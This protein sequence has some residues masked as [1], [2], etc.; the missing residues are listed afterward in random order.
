M[1]FVSLTH[2]LGWFLVRD[3]GFWILRMVLVSGC[4]A[5]P[6]FQFKCHS[7]T[8]SPIQVPPD[9]WQMT[10]RTRHPPRPDWAGALFSWQL[11][12]HKLRLNKCCDATAPLEA[13]NV[14]RAGVAVR[15]FE[16]HYV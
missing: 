16:G 7:P 3:H 12:W 11:S 10:S 1:L 2:L 9:T 15:L 6:V 4:Q 13:A 8:E 5:Q 14:S